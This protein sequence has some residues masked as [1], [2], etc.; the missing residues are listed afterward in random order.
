LSEQWSVAGGAR[1][2]VTQTDVIDDPQKLASIGTQ[3]HPP[4]DP[5]P[6]AD[7]LG[8]GD[9]D[10]TF[11][12]WSLY[13]TS[14]YQIA[15]CWTAEFAAGYAQ[16]PPT[17]TELYA[18]ETFMFVLQNGLNTVT[19]DPR[20]KPEQLLQS[21]VAL[22]YERDNLRARLNGFFGW[23]WDYVTFENMN[24]V[25]GPPVGE[26]V[27]EQLKFVN[28]DLATFIGGELYGEWDATAWLTPFTSLS[29]VAGTD[30]TR[31]GHFATKQVTP[32]TPPT[33]SVRVPGLPR[34]SYSGIP[35]AE[36]EPLPGIV[37]L[38]SR[39]G[40]RIH[41]ARPTPRWSIELAARIVDDQ[42]RI[43]TSLLEKPTPGFTVWDLRGYW[44]VTPH[45]LTIAGVENF[46]DRNYREHLNFTSQ[47]GTVQVYQPGVNFYL[48][49]ELSY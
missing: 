32:G 1:F 6:L 7:V 45:L 4:S 34:G 49:S 28:T 36:Q 11:V 17:L 26:V 2:D 41:E 25:Y 31:N 3:S 10:R 12:M 15:D 48:A 44:R 23:A 42:D 40:L 29:Y 43:A 16:R 35:G 24:V 8:S 14:Q 37:P 5:I 13:L 33:P 47:D 38:E 21:D 30:R 18:A 20:L 19:G 46:T 39:V 9:F 27:Q 22:R